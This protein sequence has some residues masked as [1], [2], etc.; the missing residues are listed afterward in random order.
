MKSKIKAEWMK[1]KRKKL[2]LFAVAFFLFQVLWITATTLR[3]LDRHPE[4]VD[5]L[6]SSC[7]YNIVILNALCMPLFV[8]V[9]VSRIC[10]MEHKGDTFKTLLVLQQPGSLF[11]IKFFY[12]VLIVLLIALLQGI[13]L[14]VFPAA[15]GCE[16]TLSKSLWLQQFLGTV[17][18]SSCVG[19]LQLGVS[20]RYPNQVPALVL[21]IFGSFLGMTSQLFPGYISRWI[22]WYYF[23]VLSII[24]PENVDGRTIAY[25]LHGLPALTCVIVAGLG[26]LFLVLGLVRFSKKEVV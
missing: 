12:T 14:S 1:L 20:M 23:S 7:I 4:E 6:L 17:L 24:T 10:D 2:F 16:Q 22:L 19:A 5:T 26:I 11:F 21:G 13:F 25:H 8:S 15:L 9:I 3:M 18:I